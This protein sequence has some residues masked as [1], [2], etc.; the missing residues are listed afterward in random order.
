MNESYLASYKTACTCS[1]NTQ[2]S[3]YHSFVEWHGYGMWSEL[4]HDNF[5][6]KKS[7]VKFMAKVYGSSVQRFERNHLN[8]IIMKTLKVLSVMLASASVASAVT[9]WGVT[10]NNQLVSFSSS[11]PGSFLSV[12]PITGL[13][14]SD[15]VTAD[16]NASIVNL[17]FNP[18]SGQFMG[19]D[20]N[21]NIY[22][23]GFSGSTTLL[24]NTFA[25]TGF[26]AGFA[27]DPFNNNFVYAG[28]NA[29]N[30]SIS[31]GGVAI[32]NSG[33]T[34]AGGGSP[35]TFALGIDPFFGTAFTIDSFTNSLYT[36]T[37]PLFPT[38]SELTLV[39]ALGVD[40][41]G[42]GGLVVD[43]DGNLLASL[44]TDGITSSLYSINSVTGSSTLIGGIGGGAGL[45]AIAVPEPSASLLGALSALFLLRRRRA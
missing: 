15:G 32:S 9:T 38:N 18:T 19:I 27:F 43:E 44:S 40:V 39:G 41:T 1:C 28:D 17:A 35:A 22:S 16:P 29:E 21:A 37:N 20:S 30:F 4:S 42:F 5:D 13:L 7:S 45:A 8:N 10:T 36:S 24:N 3:D 14:A 12:S 23:V 6:P 34:Y 2:D 33:F 26:A 25:P 11:A 31:Q